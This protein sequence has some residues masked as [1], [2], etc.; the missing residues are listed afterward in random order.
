[1]SETVTTPGAAPIEVSL[2]DTMQIE[3]AGE[4]YS[5]RR[6]AFRR[7]FKH[8][9][10]I[11]GMTIVVLLIL[12]A[13][14]APVVAPFS[15]TK[16]HFSDVRVAPGS[17]YY[18]GTDDLGRDVLSRLIIAARISVSVG[19]VAV[20]LYEIIAVFL[21]SISGYFGGA[22]DMIVQRL[23]DI[24][25]SFPTM[26]VIL[27]FI[28]FLGPSIFNVMVA[29]GLLSWPGPTRLVRGQILQQREALYVTAARSL[30]VPDLRVIIRHVLPGVVG[31][32]IV[33]ATFGVALAILTEAALSF[34]GLG[35]QLPQP[36]WGNMLSDAQS[37][38]ILS[39]MPWLW[40]PPGVAI[41][42]TV[43]CINF[44]GDGLRDALDPRMRLD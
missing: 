37:L 35:V 8:R 11:F 39:R 30:G 41:L 42:I 44:I 28:A 21:G 5:P 14:F 31:P 18:L 22:V 40:L 32:V 24:A 10:A 1:M 15:A 7:F 20:G 3:D 27:V 4:R 34:L 23:V 9:L 16:T 43:L 26:I 33:H 6:R 19:I 38:T 13:V 2:R 25:M 12:I 36:S 29:I 17:P